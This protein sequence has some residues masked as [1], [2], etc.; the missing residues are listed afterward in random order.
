MLVRQLGLVLGFVMFAWVPLAAACGDGADE[1]LSP[2]TT[3]GEF[4]GT[5][6]LGAALSETG[7]YSVEGAGATDTDSVRTALR[8]M[9]ADTFYGP[10][11]FDDRGVNVAKPM[12]TIQVQDGDIFVVAPDAAAVAELNYPL[13]S[14]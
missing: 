9:S 13:G 1:S 3:S 12:G 10:I 11:S 6:R 4:A 7:K 2:G 14:G 8:E 5:I